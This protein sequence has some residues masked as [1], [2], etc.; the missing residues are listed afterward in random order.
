MQSYRVNSDGTISGV[1]TITATT[2]DNLPKEY[3]NLTGSRV[4]PSETAPGVYLCR[5]G[6]KVTKVILR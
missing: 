1:E 4:N 3:Y 6:D 2:D 5:Q